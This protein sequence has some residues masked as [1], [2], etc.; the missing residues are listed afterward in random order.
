MVSAAMK[1]PSSI[2]SRRRKMALGASDG[3]PGIAEGDFLWPYTKGPLGVICFPRV[4]K[5]MQVKPMKK[6]PWS[7][8]LVL[9]G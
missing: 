1:R 6:R 9:L 8:K 4:L 7:S 2:G 3:K 5:E